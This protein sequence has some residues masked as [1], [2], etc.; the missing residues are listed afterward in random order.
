MNILHI[1]PSYKPAYIYGGP[2]ESVARLCEGLVAAGNTVHVYTTTANGKTELEVPVGQPVDVEG[3]QVTYFKRITKDP[4]HISPALWKA[5]NQNV[6]Q[7]DVVHIH[8]WWNILVMVA[9]K[10]CLSK[11]AKVIIAP[12][13]MLSR[14][15]F[16]SGSSKVK[17]LIHNLFGRNLL[18]KTQFHATAQA[19]YIECAELIPGWKG[20]VLPNIIALP[21]IPIKH[22]QNDAFT[23]IFLSRIHPKK[24]LEILIEAISKVSFE[25]RLKIAGNGDEE[26]IAQLKQLAVQ[27]RVDY[28]IEWLGWM[29]REQ[30][31][32]E[33]MNAD[34]F[35]LISLNENFANV[36]IE[37]LHVGTAV[38]ISEDVALSA[39][40]KEKDMGWVCGLQ[41][42]DVVSKLTDAQAQLA[43]RNHIRTTGRDVIEENFSEQKLIKSY[44]EHYKEVAD[45]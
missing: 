35:T 12:R 34:L 40:I 27:I 21:D 25:V 11:K 30:K 15:I 43:K 22:Q 29:N 19:E 45:L 31:F 3:V 18:A 37:S 42:D 24:G 10:I 36:V 38:L 4:T 5:L 44:L 2:I 33:L 1:V 32:V 41:T 8:S 14:Y 16:N 13:G 26:Y 17:K 23:L 20:F 39:F 9:A 7:Y 6:S 28:K